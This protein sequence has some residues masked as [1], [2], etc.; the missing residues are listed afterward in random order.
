MTCG[1]IHPSLGGIFVAYGCREHAYQHGYEILVAT[2]FVA[3]PLP[4]RK[5]QSGMPKK[6]QGDGPCSSDPCKTQ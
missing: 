1:K 5:Y 6:G 2:G 3:E 4:P